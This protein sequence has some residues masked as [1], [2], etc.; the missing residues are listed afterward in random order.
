[1]NKTPKNFFSPNSGFQLRNFYSI[2][3]FFSF[4]LPLL[5]ASLFLLAPSLFGWLS[6]FKE[7]IWLLIATAV[8]QIIVFGL[9]KITKRPIFWTF[10]A[11]GWVVFY[12]LMLM[13]TGGAESPFIFFLVMPLLSSTVS[14]D[15]REI[16][17]IAVATTL[18]LGSVIIVFPD[19][20][21]TPSILVMHIVNT[22]IF[23]VI[24]FYLYNVVREILTLRD[25]KEITKQKIDD[26][27]EIDKIKK[28]FLTASSHKLRTPLTAAKWSLGELKNKS[29]NE[30]AQDLVHIGDQKIDE[31]LQLVN[32]FLQV[33]QIDIES[34]DQKRN[35]KTLL[36]ELL[37]ETVKK[38]KDL[39]KSNKVTI[40]LNLDENPNPVV[41]DKMLL[42]SALSVIVENAIYYSPKGKVTIESASL[43]DRV[44]VKVFD[45]GIGIA[46][47]D[48]SHI[49]E[50]FYRADNAIILWPDNVGLGLFLAK[51]IIE[52]VGGG[53]SVSS[54]LGEGTKVEIFLPRAN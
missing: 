2:V 53:I 35:E 23:A 16:K 18:C 46:K 5:I 13:F 37:K 41:V 4:A 49:F 39:A 48:L 24:G 45:T 40:N 44:L 6:N 11:A 54:E 22:G 20:Y 31:T 8:F 14:L 10:F 47:E 43:G 30:E 29:L 7:L 17:N 51:R 27:R 33:I 38:N 3:V 19:Q 28:S 34:L 15:L 21:S 50:Q 25:E 1:V 52:K 9:H 26:L 12:F 32:K 42:L 36:E